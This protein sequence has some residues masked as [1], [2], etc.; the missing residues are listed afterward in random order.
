LN[1]QAALICTYGLEMDFIYHH[2]TAGRGAEG[3]HIVS[4]VRALKAQGHDVVVI[5]PPGVDPLENAGRAPLDKSDSRVSGINRLWKWISRHLPQ[6]MFELIEL[7]Y[8][9]YALLRLP[10]IFSRRRE[11]VL[12]ERYAFFLFA[13]VLLAKWFS[14]K[15]ILEV[16]EVT[17]IARARGQVMVPL[18]RWLERVVFRRADVIVTV[19]SFLRGEVLSRGGQPEA[20]LLLPNAIDPRRFQVSGGGRLVREKHGLLGG[21]VVGFVGWFDHWDRLDLLLDA[22]AQ[23]RQDHLDVRV[24]LVG[25]GPV[26]PALRSQI[27]RLGLQNFV[28]LTGVVSPQEVPNHIDAMDICVLPDSNPFGS[29]MVLFEFMA[30]G[31]AVVAPDLPPVRDVLQHGQTGLIIPAG[32]I[33]GLRMAI[34]LLV[35]DAALRQRLGSEAQKKVMREH[36]WEA[37]VKRVVE[38]V[39]SN[40]VVV[41]RSSY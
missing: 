3:A 21:K 1:T 12:Y 11:A 14:R 35:E 26:A 33:T 41:E 38:R 30:M 13:G 34:T 5:S 28:V 39:Q 37:N 29:P 6:L 31:K 19:S 36:T 18:A 32:D 2:R 27:E 24:L 17:G 10:G 40:D 7:A 16:N 23:L 25:D 20:V 8:N 15:V 4:V 9:G 22:V